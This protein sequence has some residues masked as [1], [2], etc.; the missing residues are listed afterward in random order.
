MRTRIGS[1]VEQGIGP[2]GMPSVCEVENILPPSCA[3]GAFRLSA[4]CVAPTDEIRKHDDGNPSKRDH[5][6]SPGGKE[7]T[8]ILSQVS[9]LFAVS[10]R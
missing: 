10:G 4:Y 6:Y 8:D 7:R 3:F 5:G 1:S 2:S 9:E